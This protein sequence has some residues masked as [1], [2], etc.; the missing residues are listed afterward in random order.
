[1]SENSFTMALSPLNTL[2]NYCDKCPNIN[3]NYFSK[4]SDY[5]IQSRYNKNLLQ[6]L[7]TYYNPYNLLQLLQL[8]TTL[9]TNYNLSQQ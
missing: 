2:T 5:E 7:T 6:H 3:K 4:S 1:M 9:T 8:I